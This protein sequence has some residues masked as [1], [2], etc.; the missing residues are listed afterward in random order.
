[1]V[2]FT[3]NRIVA[4]VA[5]PETWN[6]T[7]SILPLTASRPPCEK[8]PHWVREED[9]GG[10][11]DACEVR[12]GRRRRTAVHAG[13]LR[14][15][16]PPARRARRPRARAPRAA[17]RGAAARAPRACHARPSATERGR[18]YRIAPGELPFFMHRERGLHLDEPDV[19]V[20]GKPV[21]AAI[22]GTALTLFYAGRVQADRGQSIYFYLPKLEHAPEAR[23]YRDLFDRSRELLPALRRAT[24]RAIVLVESLPCVYEMDEMLWELGPYAAGL[25]AARWDLKASIF[26]F[27]MA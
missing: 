15:P 19:T 11:R 13:V 23:W 6:R 8:S 1:M 16:G 7:R 21:N 20:D 5:L 17:H 12:S 14:V 18:S 24:I 27:V 26:E 2:A 25:N 9:H 3:T 10:R 22:L 4:I